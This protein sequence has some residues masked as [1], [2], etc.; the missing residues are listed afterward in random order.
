MSETIPG[1]KMKP[2]IMYKVVKGTKCRTLLKGD[3]IKL[4]INGNLI[5]TYA[6]GWL[7]PCDWA[8][9]A[10]KTRV[11]LDTEYYK[12]KTEKLKHEIEETESSLMEGGE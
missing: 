4:D 7:V 9:I 12:Q 8:E 2:M 1:D 5:C 3:R 10:S 11:T 6:G